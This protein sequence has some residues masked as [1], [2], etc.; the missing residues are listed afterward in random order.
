[1]NTLLLLIIAVLMVATLPAWPHS[2]KWGYFPSVGLG[3]VLIL[4]LLLILFGQI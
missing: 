2:R 1:M 4:M 3:V